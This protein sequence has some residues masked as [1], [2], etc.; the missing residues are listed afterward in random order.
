[1]ENEEVKNE[2][3]QDGLQSSIE[4][5]SGKMDLTFRDDQHDYDWIL[6]I[7][8]RGKPRGIRFRL[9]DSGIFE[10]HQLEKIVGMVADL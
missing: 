9:V 10:G 8:N 3:E 5:I 1:M 6:D 2:P 7:L 4:K